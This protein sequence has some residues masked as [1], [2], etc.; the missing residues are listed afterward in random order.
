V[1][2]PRVRTEH[3]VILGAAA[4]LVLGT[5]LLGPRLQGAGHDPRDEKRASAHYTTPAG[6]RA[7]YEL[8]GELDLDVLLHQRSLALLPPDA[9]V[10][11]LLAPKVKV[12]KEDVDALR[13]FVE[14]GG[15]LV[16]AD[17]KPDVPKAFGVE[18]TSGHE[19]LGDVNL[20]WGGRE[21]AIR[22]TSPWRVNDAALVDVEVERGRFVALADAAIASNRKISEA[23]HALLLTHLAASGGG[24]IVFDEYHHGFQAGQ[25]AMSIILDSPLAGAIWIG[26]A[27]AYLAVIAAGRRLGPPVDPRI[28][29]RRRPRETLEAFAGLCARLRARPQAAA[30]VAEEFRHFLRARF[31][32]TT[33]EEAG[34]V[35]AR[36]GVDRGELD[37]VLELLQAIQRDPGASERDLVAAF[38]DVERLRARFLEARSPA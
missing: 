38:Q 32:A 8:L 11:F 15:T 9:R 6:G 26:L 20:R 17:D 28:E 29:R 3:A 10:L 14:N 27:A 30:L 2:T 35:A 4:V 24:L 18:L 1:K 16:W 23:D 7:L 36:L 12:E 22:S 21:Y 25:G 31:G 5:V 37:R 19:A 33:P 34:R 13:R